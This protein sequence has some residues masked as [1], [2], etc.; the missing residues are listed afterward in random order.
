MKICFFTV[1]STYLHCLYALLSTAFNIIILNIGCDDLDGKSYTVVS[2]NLLVY[3]HILYSC[4]CVCVCMYI[5]VFVYLYVY[6]LI[7]AYALYW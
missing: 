5:Y 6:I 3:I 7:Y 4:M 1:G 2:T